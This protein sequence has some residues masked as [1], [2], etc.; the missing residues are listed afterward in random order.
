MISRTIPVLIMSE[1]SSN[2]KNR[3]GSE[4]VALFTLQPHDTAGSP[5]D[6]AFSHPECFG[7]KT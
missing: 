3:E 4:N 7:C 6:F 5:G 2:D 1:M